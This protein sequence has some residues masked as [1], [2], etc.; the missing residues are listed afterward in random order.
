MVPDFFSM[1]SN[2]NF[3]GKIIQYFTKL[4]ILEMCIINIII[5]IFQHRDLF[6]ASSHSLFMLD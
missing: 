2:K 5:S 3:R 1:A 6:H 4:S